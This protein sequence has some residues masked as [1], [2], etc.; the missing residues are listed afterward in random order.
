MYKLIFFVETVQDRHGSERFPACA[1]RLVAQLVSDAVAYDPNECM[2]AGRPG[3]LV[4]RL[5]HTDTIHEYTDTIHE[6]T[7]YKCILYMVK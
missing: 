5:N 7:W 2:A 4:D 1:P 3:F 6:Y